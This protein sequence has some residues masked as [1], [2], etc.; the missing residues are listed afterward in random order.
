MQIDHDGSVFNRKYDI[1]FPILG[2]LNIS[3]QFLINELKQLGYSPKSYP[4]VPTK[5]AIPIDL[6]TA[7]FNT[8]NVLY[9]LQEYLP[10]ST[11]Y[12]IDIG[13]FMSYVIHCMQVPESGAFDINVHFGAMGTA[14]GSAIG[15]ALADPARPVACITGDGCFF[16][17][18]MEILTAREYG[19]P[20]LFV[21]MNNSR[22]GM[23]CHGHILQ[24]KRSHPRF[25]QQPVNIAAMAAAMGIP[26]ARIESLQDL[27]RELVDDLHTAGPSL[28]EIALVDNNIPPIGDRVNFLSSF[29]R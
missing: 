26:S 6:K 29:G 27:T 4:P 28:L 1:D 22:L 17:H 14:I 11:R 23:V 10:S 15:A 16:M 9:A 19:L 18:G 21:V 12:T 5:Q 2:D 20:I 13:E 3:L 25:E 7:E 24:Y 8:K